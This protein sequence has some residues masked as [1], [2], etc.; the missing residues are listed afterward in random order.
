MPDPQRILPAVCKRM[1]GG[2][3]EYR[4]MSQGAW[5]WQTPESWFVHRVAR[6]CHRCGMHV[7]LPFP[8]RNEGVF[9]FN[10]EHAPSHGLVGRPDMDLT[11]KDARSPA[12][13]VALVRCI[14]SVSDARIRDIT[15]LCAAI[16]DMP[17]DAPA[18]G[19]F[20][21]ATDV[22]D[23]GGAEACIAI[24]KLRFQLLVENAIAQA[25]AHGLAPAD[26]HLA[27]SDHAPGRGMMAA[28]A[29]MLARPS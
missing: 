27:F 17:G 19:V 20:C 28:G 5:L 24:L 1:I 23:K 25:E 14:W 4:A 16:G 29:I 13:G 9:P 3:Y 8:A 7:A 10:E 11:L 18:F 22:P 26:C 6:A 15:R 2:F 12:R 21:M